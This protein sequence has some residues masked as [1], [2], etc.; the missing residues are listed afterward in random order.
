MDLSPYNPMG[1]RHFDSLVQDIEKALNGECSAIAYYK[2][3]SQIAS[4]PEQKERIREI[5]REEIKHFQIFSGIYRAITGQNPTLRITKEC[6]DDYREGLKVSFIDEQE[7]V[8]FYLRI[9]D[10]AEDFF[11]REPFRRAAA[12]EQNHAVW[13]SFFYLKNACNTQC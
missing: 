10:K 7:T 5:R 11:I 13:F 9:A 2:K 1:P 3:L 12:D 6:P 4:V 8:D